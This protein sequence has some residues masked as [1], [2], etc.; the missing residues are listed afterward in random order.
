[1]A[2]QITVARPYAEAVFELARERDAL[3]VWAE[4]LRMASS[5]ASDDRVRMALDNPRL[6][7]A[8][9]NVGE[10]R[11]GRI[12]PLGQ[13]A[14]GGIQTGVVNSE[15]HFTLLRNWIRHLRQTQTANTDEIV[16]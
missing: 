7:V 6:A 4:M 3:P 11:V 13:V 14:V 10:G 5:V 15:D 8:A 1:M 16:E 12:L 9:E 2:E